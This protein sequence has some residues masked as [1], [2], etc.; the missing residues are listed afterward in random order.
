MLSEAESPSNQVSLPTSWLS[1]LSKALFSFLFLL[2]FPQE[3]EW[4]RKAGIE[5]NQESAASSQKQ[6]PLHV[7]HFLFVEKVLVS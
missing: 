6:K 2:C 1:S 3:E 4:Q 5:T 7:S